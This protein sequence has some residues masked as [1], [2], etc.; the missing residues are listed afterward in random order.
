MAN[1][2]ARKDYTSLRKGNSWTSLIGWL[3]VGEAR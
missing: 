2:L 1:Y 3:V